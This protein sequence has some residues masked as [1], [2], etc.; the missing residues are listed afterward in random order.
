MLDQYKKNFWGLQVFIGLT[1]VVVIAFSH[2]PPLGAL[3]FVVM[4]L[5][6]VLGAMWA[7]RLKDKFE[8]GNAARLRRT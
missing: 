3:F 5:S 2:Q 8:A 1:A 4:Q 7:K 6:G